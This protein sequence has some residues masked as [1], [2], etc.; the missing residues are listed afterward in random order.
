MAPKKQQRKVNRLRCF[1]L[2]SIYS[3]A[4]TPICDCMIIDLSVAGARVLPLMLE[5]VPDYFRLDLG[6]VR[7]KCKVRWR[8][9]NDLGVQFY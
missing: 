9:E 7:P 1:H 6:P 8:G 2:G 4:G 3:V 5:V